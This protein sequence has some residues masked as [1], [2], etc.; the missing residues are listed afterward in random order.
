MSVPEMENLA[1]QLIQE[2][3][4]KARIDSKNKVCF[5]FSTP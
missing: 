3:R 5:H 1:A 4:I 2:G